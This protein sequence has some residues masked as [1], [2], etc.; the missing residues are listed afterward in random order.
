MSCRVASTRQHFLHFSFGIVKLP[1]KNNVVKISQSEKLFKSFAAAL[2]KKENPFW[3]LAPGAAVSAVFGRHT[4]HP[5]ARTRP[6]PG[7]VCD[8]VAWFG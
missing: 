7:P 5:R 2:E 6:R 1:N 3:L 8:C 4:R